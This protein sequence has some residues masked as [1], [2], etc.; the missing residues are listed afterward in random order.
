MYSVQVGHKK[1]LVFQAKAGEFAFDIDAKGKE[2]ISPPDVLLASLGSCIG[3]YIRKYSDG[4]RLDLKDFSIT[5]SADLSPE[6]PVRF[7][8]IEVAVNLKGSLTD[9]RR[10]SALLE[11]IKNCPVHNTLKGSP[12]VEVNVA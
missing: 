6:A 10:I 12:Q 11:F 2:G 5:L 4:A 9:E 8:R 1:D 7:Q 3:V